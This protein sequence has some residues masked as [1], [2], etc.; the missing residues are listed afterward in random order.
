VENSGDSDFQ[1]GLGFLPGYRAMV[2]LVTGE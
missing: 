1:E 2:T